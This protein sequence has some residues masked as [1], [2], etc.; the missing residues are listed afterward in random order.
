MWGTEPLALWAALGVSECL[1]MSLGIFERHSGD[2]QRHPETLWDTQSSFYSPKEYL[3]LWAAQVSLGVSGCP[4]NVSGVSLGIFKRQSRDI[5]RHLEQPRSSDGFQRHPETPETPE[6][7]RVPNIL[8]ENRNYLEQPGF[9]QDQ[10][11]FFWC[12]GPQSCFLIRIGMSFVE[13][14]VIFENI[15]VCMEEQQFLIEAGEWWFAGG[16]GKWWFWKEFTVDQVCCEI[17][18]TGDSKKR[19]QRTGETLCAGCKTGSGCGEKI[20]SY[21][22]LVYF[23]WIEFVCEENWNYSEQGKEMVAEI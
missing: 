14:K 17:V 15:F 19:G 3:A 9:L 11:P 16:D 13:G 6:Q 18:V 7:P 10:T 21:E 1:W 8:W 22:V 2:I 4:W 23:V 20:L 12:H 5:Q